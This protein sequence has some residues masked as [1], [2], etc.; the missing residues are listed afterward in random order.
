MNA[1]TETRQS[2]QSLA[3]S[4]LEAF[5]AA[6]DAGDAERLSALFTADVQWR[7]MLALT[8]NISP[9]HD[10]EEVVSSL[11]QA[12]Q[13]MAAYNFRLTEGRTPARLV[14][15]GGAEVIE[16]LFTFETNIARCEGVLR[17]PLAAPQTAC[18]F[19][20]SMKE[21]KGHEEPIFNNR[22]SG[23]TYSRNFGGKNWT[24]LR[25]EEAQFADRDPYVL[26]V[27]ASQFGV[28]LAAR[29]RLLGVDALVVERTPRV[30]DQ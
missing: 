26:I 7:D 19:A 15:R 20:S 27:G 16:A 5:S 4:W 1:V 11:L 18:V 13:R 30:G 9:H 10:R 28:T 23:E 21:L 8:W 29:L 25:E 17:L 3:A 22:P 2:N 14:R 6:L 24:D 12:S